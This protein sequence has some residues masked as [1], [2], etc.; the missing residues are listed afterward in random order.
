VRRDVQHASDFV[1]QPATAIAL[2]QTN[3]AN[4]A[5]QTAPIAR[6]SAALA[7]CAL[8][9]LAQ[10]CALEGPIN[11]TVPAAGQPSVIV[12]P[13]GGV[14]LQPPVD[15]G[16]GVPS[17]LDPEQIFASRCATS[18]VKSSLLPSNLLFV[19]DR[20]GSMACNPPPIT[21]SDVCERDE[22]RADVA[23]PSKWELTSNQLMAAIRTLPDSAGV[24]MSYFSNDDL[25][26]VSAVP[27]VPVSRNT[28]GQL[29][30]IATTL[31]ALSKKVPTGSTPLVGATLLAYDYFH[32]AA[33]DGTIAGNR[34]VVL[35]TD[36]QQSAACNDATQC[37]TAEECSELLIRKAAIA[38]GPGVNIRTFVIGVPGSELGRTVLSRLANAGGT[39]LARCVP[40]QGDCHF[41]VTRE[42]DLRAGLQRALQSIAGQ[43]LTCELEVPEHDAAGTVDIQRLNVVFTPHEGNARVIPV[44]PSLPCD[45]GADGWQYDPTKRLIRLCG[46]SC[47]SVRNDRG[48]RIDVVLGCPVIGPD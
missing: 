34:Y 21:P 11:V 14:T 41:D 29:T 39:G 33:L 2:K 40:E 37:N 18:T 38:S 44:S 24:G 35:I 9:S 36:G 31:S 23:A 47:T 8:L 17:T 22:Q 42:V 25:C 45:A 27:A 28:Q 6:A 16:M 30:L 10:A 20:S 1:T 19:M 4:R 7:Q 48:G 43:T 13:D 3:R 5:K 46:N 12:P 26:G 15:A 32:N